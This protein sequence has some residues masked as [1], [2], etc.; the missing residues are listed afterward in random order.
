MEESNKKIDLTLF[1]IKLGKKVD[2]TFFIAHFVLSLFFDLKNV[3][4]LAQIK[5]RVNGRRY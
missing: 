5:R 3:L 1:F 4:L 2:F